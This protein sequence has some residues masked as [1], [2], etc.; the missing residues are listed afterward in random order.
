MF[1]FGHFKFRVLHF[2]DLALPMLIS[3]MKT[4]KLCSCFTKMNLSYIRRNIPQTTLFEKILCKVATWR[5]WK[6][7]EQRRRFYSGRQLA[8]ISNGVGEEPN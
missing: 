7:K 3:T 5:S 6:I 8:G 2:A 4:A 1:R